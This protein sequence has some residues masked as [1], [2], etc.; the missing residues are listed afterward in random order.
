MWQL[1]L[2]SLDVFVERQP[3]LLQY[4]GWDCKSECQHLCMWK[5]VDD[6]DKDGIPQQQYYGKA[7]AVIFPLDICLFCL[8][9]D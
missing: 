1:F 5:A 4:L 3:V 2:E 9:F 8:A 6:F 7:S